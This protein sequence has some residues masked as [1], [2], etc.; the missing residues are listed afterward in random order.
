M[1]FPQRII[2]GTPVPRHQ[3]EEDQDRIPANKPRGDRP[4]SIVGNIRAFFFKRLF[5]I[6]V[7]VPTVVATLFYSAIASKRYVSEARFVVR[8]VSAP[9]VSGL[10]MLF[11]TFG[12]ARTVDDANLIQKYL[13]SRD[14]ITAL[15]NEGV[16]LR[17]IFTRPEGDLPSRYPRF[18][19]KD[20]NEALHDYFMD[21]VSVVDEQSKGILL[22]R[23]VT[24]RPEDSQLLARK[25][26]G[27]AEAMV[28]R[29]NDRAQRDTLNAAMREVSLA[30]Q[31]VIAAQE[32]LTEY[33]NL[34]IL[35]DPSKTSMSIIET[36]GTLSTD[37]SY[38][39][40]QLREMETNSP[41]N[42]SLGGL[43]AKIASLEERIRIERAKMAGGENSLTDKI[44]A[45]EQLA[46]RRDLADKSL[47]S[48]LTS[49]EFARQEAR[50]QH[51][52]IEQVTAANLADESTEPQRLRAIASVF[53]IGFAA[54]ALTWILSVAAGEHSQ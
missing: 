51:I 38:A 50:R 14:I 22:L 20:T 19:R 12:L 44:S 7:V 39:S 37:L 52:Y 30:E 33:R 27:L 25:M 47:A 32:A 31:Q 40:A 42:P 10:D 26:L 16:D 1:K 17:Q 24:F 45:Y 53:V 48:A 54:F 34:E 18:W 46:L 28:N 35:V 29:M 36:I 41:N 4:P 15:T 3:P 13:L 23:V 5:L 6:L 43:R 11:R 9:R 49:T 21:R 2:A 8:S